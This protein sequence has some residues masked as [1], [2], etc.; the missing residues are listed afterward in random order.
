M[1]NLNLKNKTALITGAS[2]SIG[3]SIAKKLSSLGA[4][5]IIT[6]RNKKKIDELKKKLKPNNLAIIAD[7]SKDT[8]IENLSE[9]SIKQLSKLDIIINI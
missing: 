8:E 9:K 3:G 7:L 1:T 2:G 5:V 6:G 4:N